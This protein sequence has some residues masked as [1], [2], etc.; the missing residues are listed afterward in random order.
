MSIGLDRPNVHGYV[1]T[2]HSIVA[3]C[4]RDSRGRRRPR[5]PGSGVAI[6]VLAGGALATV[7]L[8]PSTSR[9]ILTQEL[10]EE[11]EVRDVGR[12]QTSAVGC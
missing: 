5:V 4:A 7:R 2:S 9:S 10:A 1:G 6:H 3:Q 11:Q 12:L 8:D